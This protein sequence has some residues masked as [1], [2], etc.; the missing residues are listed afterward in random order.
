MGHDLLGLV[1]GIPTL[2]SDPVGGAIMSLLNTHGGVY[3]PMQETSGSVAVARN[4]AQAV[5]RNIV[6]N[7]GF[8]SDTIWTKGTGWSIAG[9]VA[10]SDGSQASSSNLSQGVSTLVSRTWRV[11]FTISNRVSGT[12]RV[13]TG[14]FDYTPLRSADGTYIEEITVSNPSS[15]NTIYI[16]ADADFVGDID[17]VTCAQLNIAA[18][19]GYFNG[20]ITGA[21]VGQAA[22]PRIG[23]AY[24]F[25]GVNDVIDIATTELNS[26]INPLAWTVIVFGKVSGAGVWTDGVNR[27]LIALRHP[28]IAALIDLAKDTPNNNLIYT[29]YADGISRSVITTT[30]T[31]DWFVYVACAN[32]HS[33]RTYLNGV[34]NASVPNDAS[35]IPYNFGS[36]KTNIGAYL[37][38]T[39]A[40]PWSGWISRVAYLRAEITASEALRL[41]QLAGV[42]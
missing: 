22:S 2:V 14:G 35:F 37:S 32:N 27:R 23:K 15:N 31:T 30:S 29:V 36:P 24:L 4:T 17:N 16:Q 28:T 40:N 18:D 12:I 7:G 26:L 34:A 33:I 3:W 8:D 21:T 41:A 10:H 42:A 19:S 5:G 1:T 13:S 39:G 9:G 11:T 6:L 25:D 38:N 20:A